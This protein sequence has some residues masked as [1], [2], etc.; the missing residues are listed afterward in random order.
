MGD[1]MPFFVES[2][3]VCSGI[4]IYFYQTAI[5]PCLKI[6]VFGGIIK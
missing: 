5:M 1:V 4:A 2:N 6:N 3:G